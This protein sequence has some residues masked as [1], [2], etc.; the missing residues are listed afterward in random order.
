MKKINEIIND[1]LKNCSIINLK[2]IFGFYRYYIITKT[3]F[4]FLYYDNFNEIF[5][6]I[7]NKKISFIS[8]QK[9]R[10]IVNEMYINLVSM[11]ELFIFLFDKCI[12]IF[13]N[14]SILFDEF[15]KESIKV[16]HNLKKGNKECLHLEYYIISIIEMII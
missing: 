15:L 10:D 16:D 4:K 2:K 8:L 1:T 5:N 3:K 14:N 13:K 9:I 11:Q 7:N 12:D 6:L